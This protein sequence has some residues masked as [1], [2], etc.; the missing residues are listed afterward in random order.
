MQYLIPYIL[1]A[2]YD[3]S[4]TLRLA[5]FGILKILNTQYEGSP[6]ITH[7]FQVGG[8]KH[9][10]VKCLTTEKASFLTSN[11][12]AR[13]TEIIEDRSKLISYIGDISS[14]RYLDVKS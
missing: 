10:M 1:M 4:R 8:V 14:D 6:I 2:C 11:I 5:A 12:L 7:V 9:E 3:K 13:Q